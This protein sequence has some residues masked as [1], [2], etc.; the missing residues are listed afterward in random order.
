MTK[1]EKENLIGQLMH[2]REHIRI[3]GCDFGI[4]AIIH[5]MYKK[6][7]FKKVEKELLLETIQLYRPANFRMFLYRG[8]YFPQGQAVPRIEFINKIISIIR[9][10][11]KTS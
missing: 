8:F 10:T 5:N 6:K 4:C 1:Q 7:Q 9:T 11:Y 3:N 2:V